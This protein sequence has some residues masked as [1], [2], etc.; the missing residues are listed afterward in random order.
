MANDISAIL[1]TIYRAA[2]TVSREF[3]GFVGAA[4][5]NSSAEGAAVGQNI[6][7]PVVPMMA[8][9]N[10]TA[11]NV[12][13]AGTD[14]TIGSG[15]MTIS[16]S[17]SVSWPSTGEE[18]MALNTGDQ[19]MGN[20]VLEKQFVQA[21]RTLVNELEGDA[22]VEAYQNSSRAF[23]TAGTAPFGTANNLTD[24]AGTARVLDENGAPPFDRG[25]VLGHAAMYNLRGVQSS[26]WKVNEA[27]TDELLRRGRIAE[28]MGFNI[29]L[30]HAVGIHTKG[31]GTGYLVNNA[32]GEVVGETSIATDTG[33]GTVIAGDVVT[34]A[35]DAVNK[36]V[37]AATL[38][39]GT[40][41]IG[42]PG[43]RTQTIPDN[44]AITVGNNYTANVG[45]HRDAFHII[46]RTPAMPEGGDAAD[47]VANITDPNSGI[48]FQVAIYR[49]R[50]Q[51]VYEVGLAW[52][53]KAVK[54]AHIATLIG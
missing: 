22:W 23:G 47:D 38:S 44:N 15:T 35:A 48:S 4:F 42:A 53:V 40:F 13:P 51:V 18:Q 17:R 30:S 31:T 27:G 36:Y 25:L 5:R 6:T 2:D 43:V 21:M 7:Y 41:S 28:V 9:G 32:S 39:G 45:F 54:E 29:H 46:T 20:E 33:S 34:F 10:V 50:R 52:G 19:P 26:L 11:S 49:E 1:P 16:K 24:F 14:Q 12:L 37:V 8:A 3:V